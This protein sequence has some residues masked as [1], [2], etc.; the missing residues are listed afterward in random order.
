MGSSRTFQVESWSTDV[1]NVFVYVPSLELSSIETMV[2][3]G[4]VCATLPYRAV[5]AGACCRTAP[6]PNDPEM[7]RDGPQESE[8]AL[9]PEPLNSTTRNNKTI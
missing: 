9:R 2:P 4:A 1:V 7:Q 6:W 3:A 5:R 8:G